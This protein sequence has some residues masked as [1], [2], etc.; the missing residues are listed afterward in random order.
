MEKQISDLY[1]SYSKGQLSRRN[2]LRK[3]AIIAGS[4]AAA[5]TLLPVLE[6]NHARAGSLKKKNPGLITEF[7]NYPAEDGEVRAY[8]A[9]PEVEEKLPAVIVIHENKGLQPHIQDVTRRMASEGFLTIAPD[10][11]SPLGGTPEEVNEARSLMRELDSEKTLN[12]FVAAV[13]YLKTHPLST[14][15]VGCTGFCWGGGMTN[16][17]AVNSPDL[18]A[19]VPYYGRQPAVEDVPKIKASIMAHYAG[20][21]ERINSGI[22]AFEEALKAASIE[23]KFFIYEGAA[24]AFNNDLNPDRYHKE[25][26]LLAWERTVAFFK[27]K[28][29]T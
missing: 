16:Q 13:K 29:K 15:K 5:L 19:A 24:H 23:Y 18:I 12:N 14:G 21:D 3:L 2:F 28:L 20:Q 6:K 25:A 4:S 22:P 7:V 1:E 11:L 27:E 17:V 8:M 9:R 26:A 10:A